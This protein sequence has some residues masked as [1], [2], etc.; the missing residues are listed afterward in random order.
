MVAGRSHPWETLYDPRRITARALGTMAKDNLEGLAHLGD[1]FSRPDVPSEVGIEHGEGATVMDGLRRLAV[2]RDTEGVCHRF[3]A[4][5][6][7]LGGALVWNPAEK[8]WDCPLHGSRFDVEGR[9]ICGPARDDLTPADED[10]PPAHGA[11]SLAEEQAG[12][13][14]ARTPSL[15]GTRR[16]EPTEKRS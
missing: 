4:A 16:D 7:H 8:S 1:W 15:L 14:V 2:Y 6:P 11:R 10:A 3:S 12:I 13:G 5:C 9:V